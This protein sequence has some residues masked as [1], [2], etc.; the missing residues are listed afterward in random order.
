MS[1]ELLI[2]GIPI[3]KVDEARN[4]NIPLSSSG[5]IGISEVF[6]SKNTH[7]DF[8]F[9]W[10]GGNPVKTVASMPEELVIC[11]KRVKRVSFDLLNYSNFLIVSK[12][13]YDYMIAYGFDYDEDKS[14]ARLVDPKGNALTDETFYLLR[15]Y[16]W[17]IKHN[18]VQLIRDE[19][20]HDVI[21]AYTESAKDFLMTNHREY[22][23]ELFVNADLKQEITTLF[24]NPMLF[25]L[26]EWNK[27]N[28][29]DWGF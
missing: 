9:P 21:T 26:E 16:W 7:P 19:N 5:D 10:V 29:D 4:L 22:C 25:S 17:N 24:R 28:S 13:L 2:W 15:Y 11:L 18:E 14:R 1:K 6:N 27:L 3:E 12:A 8:V 23:N 20:N